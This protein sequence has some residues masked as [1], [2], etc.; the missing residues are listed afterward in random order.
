MSNDRIVALLIASIV[1]AIAVEGLSTE[2]ADDPPVVIEIHDCYD[3]NEVRTDL[4]GHY[5]LMNDID[6]SMTAEWS[7]GQGFL[8]IGTN[9]DGFRFEGVFD[10]G[11][12]SID[13]LWI[14]RSRVQYQGLFG[15]VEGG[16]ILDVNLVNTY[17]SGWAQV[18]GLCGAMVDGTIHGSSFEGT[19]YATGS[20]AGGL[21]GSFESSSMSESDSSADVFGRNAVGGLI[22]SGSGMVYKSH[23]TGITKGEHSVGGLI[24]SFRGV[25]VSSFAYNASVVGNS[26]TGGAIGSN[27]GNVTNVHSDNVSVEFSAPI[28][29]RFITRFGGLIGSNA[30]TIQESHSHG[31]VKGPSLVGG[32]VGS[33]SGTIR[34]SHSYGSVTGGVDVGGLVGMTSGGTIIDSYAR[35]DVEGLENVG[36]LIGL[37]RGGAVH[38][39]FYD[40]ETTLI[41]GSHQISIGAVPKEAF[42][43]WL[44]SE[45][46]LFDAKEYLRYE[47]GYYHIHDVDDFKTLLLLGQQESLSFRLHDN[48]DL[49]SDAGFFIPY[50][51][52]HLYGG[53]KTVSNLNITM[54]NESNLGLLGVM[55][56]STVLNVSLRN[57]YVR[58]S[59]SL[60]SLGSH[61]IRSTISDVMS[62][63]SVIGESTVGGL[64]GSLD[65]G[66]I[67]RSCFKGEVLG[68]TSAGGLVNRNDGTITRSCRYG[69]VQG[70][71]VGGL[72]EL[73][74]GT[75]DSSYSA[76]DVF[77]AGI[78]GGVA[79]F[80]RGMIN[81]SF[82]R[83]DVYAG[84]YMVGGFVGEHLNGMILNSYATG[85][86]TILSEEYFAVGAFAGRE[87]GL[88]AN[89]YSVQKIEHEQPYT[90]R[91]AMTDMR[92]EN[93]THDSVFW[94][95]DDATVTRSIGEK[96]MRSLSEM[97]NITIFLES[98]W[99][100]VHIENYS[101]QTWFIDDGR[102]YPR[103]GWEY[104]E[105]L[106][107]IETNRT[108]V[109]W[110]ALLVL[111][112]V[113][114]L[115]YY[116][117]R[118]KENT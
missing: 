20:T 81:R 30:G 89:S 91:F 109:Y 1:L 99:D 38:N 51:S 100:I 104:G 107:N 42:R 41:N 84:G 18:G 16:R 87:C 26:A 39:S 86:V 117:K 49:S 95:S 61:A 67:D 44:D 75:I 37:Y 36:G 46:S 111:L 23:S 40:Y 94:S 101:N 15:S 70:R 85:S 92:C 19:V 4:S 102:D 34:G 83:G 65:R 68:N 66:S 88:I 82:S 6:C 116:T 90:L 14:N 3:L 48:I 32:L 77:G 69:S 28:G 17:V 33:N 50:F 54:P 9:K 103:L 98:G 55:H 47:D 45:R 11:G 22:G 8:P 115:W 35:A 110:S 56:G 25:V 108:V 5:R 62:Y 13:G 21:V 59:T 57:A 79:G 53:G 74:R 10:G 63:G 52:G 7:G 78:A 118:T 97:K 12:H 27:R 114:L 43:V 93:N 80:N 76:G 64:V 73:N 72:V 106:T 2:Y 60:G 112:L 71:I 113:V 96:H 105:D 24:G 58:G 29:T 31:S